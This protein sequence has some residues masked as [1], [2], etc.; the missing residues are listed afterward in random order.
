LLKKRLDEWF[1]SHGRM[2]LVIRGA[3]QVGKS[4]LVRQFAAQ[5]GLDLH[6]INLEQNKVLTPVFASL[7]PESIIREVES[8]SGKPV[9]AGHPLLF[10]DEIQAIPEAIQSLRYLYEKM[11]QIAVIAAGSLLEFALE[12]KSF[13]MPVGR[14]EYLYLGPM[15]F[16]EFLTASAQTSLLELIRAHSL[17]KPFPVSG[18]EKLKLLFRDYLFCGGMPAAVDRYIQASSLLSAFPIHSSLL[19]TYRDDF[20]KYASGSDL[21]RIQ[22]IFE[23]I[24]QAVGQK[25]KYADF[26]LHEQPR[27]VRHAL[28]LLV[29]AGVATQ[30]YH[31]SCSGLPLSAGKNERIFK[32][33]ALDI[34]LMNS[35]NGASD[36]PPSGLLNQSLATEGRMAEQFIGQHLLY[37]GDTSRK[38][39]LFYWLR[40]GRSSNA[41]VDFVIQHKGAIVPVEVKAGKSGSLR[42]IHQFIAEKKVPLALRFDLNPPSIQHV[43]HAVNRAEGPA[44][45]SFDL[46][47]LPLYFVEQTHRLLG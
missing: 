27:A 39:Y 37:L 32:V 9:S 31:S 26:L 20:G 12:K 46:L 36:I 15:S 13:S 29:K 7:S 17:D 18:H 22:R 4:Y 28:S 11:P 30:V 21:E 2:P 38:P 23:Q 47:N 6:E 16:E 42:S 34:G 44:E 5:K 40:E 35:A 43:T 1:Q 14:I 45:I 25:F 33:L 41:E 8:I 3:R 24:P 19:E 10:I